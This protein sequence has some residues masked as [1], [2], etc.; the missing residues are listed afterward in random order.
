M[1]TRHTLQA[2]RAKQNKLEK[3]KQKKKKKKD[4]EEALECANGAYI[5]PFKCCSN[6]STVAVMSNGGGLRSHVGVLLVVV[7]VLSQCRIGMLLYGRVWWGVLGI[8]C[9]C[10]RRGYR[11]TRVAAGAA[12]TS[13][14]CRQGTLRITRRPP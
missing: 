13:S 1:R 4:D 8:A 10:A 3:S 9:R 11:L 2:E 14:R 6:D 5:R 7:A 12:A